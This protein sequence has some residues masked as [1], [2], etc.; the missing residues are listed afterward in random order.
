ME[1]LKDKNFRD[2]YKAQ[3]KLKIN[4]H[5]DMVLYL[6]IL[7]IIG[8]V[9]FLKMD[10]F[11]MSSSSSH[12]EMIFQSFSPQLLLLFSAIWAL[13]MGIVVTKREQR[14]EMNSFI[15][16]SKVDHATNIS[17]F[18]YFAIFSSITTMLFNYVTRIF[19]LLTD[20]SGIIDSTNIM[21]EPFIFIENIGIGILLLLFAMAIG[22]FLGLL[23]YKFKFVYT[24]AFVVTFVFLLWL[25]KQDLTIIYEKLSNPSLVYGSLCIAIILI[26]ALST[27]FSTAL[28]VR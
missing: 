25:Q 2:I 16:S 21:H 3:L 1:F 27:R 6:I 4:K 22:Y 9:L 23:A 10:G 26:F 24:M 7:Q 18:L 12:V 5:L 17:L 13:Y 14:L 8:E 11:L 19:L 20:S 15:A 28:E